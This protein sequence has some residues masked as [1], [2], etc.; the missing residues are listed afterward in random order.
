MKKI[1]KSKDLSV[2]LPTQEGLFDKIAGLIEQARKKVATAINQEMVLLYWNIGKTVKEEIMKSDRAE[3]GKQ[4]IQSLSGELTQRYGK[5]FS[6][7]NLWYM[8]QLYEAYPI[9][10]SLLGEFKG[11]SWTHIIILL[12]IKDDLKRQF[13]AILCQKEQ[14]STRTLDG[15]IGT[16]LYERTALSKLPEKTIEMQLQELKEEDKMT[17]ELV[18]R[19]PYVL[20]FLELNDT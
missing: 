14:W 20:D 17:P 16:M 7:Q 5:G 18:F 9:L 15:R 4:I 11:L 3:Y 6:S 13:Y 8:V 1:E 2:R 10:Q 12:P 19:D